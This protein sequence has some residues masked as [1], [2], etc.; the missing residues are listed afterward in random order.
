MHKINSFLVHPIYGVCK[1]LSIK[2]YKI[3]NDDVE[4]YE[5][6]CTVENIIVKEPVSTAKSRGVRKIISKNSALDLIKSIQKKPQDMENNWKIRCQENTDRL[7]TGDISDTLDVAKNLFIRNRV[8]ELSASEKRLYEKAYTF[9]VDELSI[10]LKKDKEE[11]EDMISTALEK[12]AKKYKPEE[13]EKK[14]EVASK[15]TKK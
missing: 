10:A 7:K 12:S 15:K 5:L 2:S 3:L 9:I 4:C 1:V 6:E 13:V 14:T 11:I 8:K